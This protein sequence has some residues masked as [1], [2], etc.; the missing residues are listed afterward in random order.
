MKAPNSS[1]VTAYAAIRKGWTVTS[2]TGP[3]PSSGKPPGSSEP[4]RKVPPSRSSRLA[5][6]TDIASLRLSAL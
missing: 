2:R 1:F 3:S 4:I 6:D 5:V